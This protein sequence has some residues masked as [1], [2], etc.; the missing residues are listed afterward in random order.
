MNSQ[1]CDILLWQYFKSCLLCISSSFNLVLH[2]RWPGR[3]WYNTL[4]IAILLLHLKYRSCQTFT[5]CY[6]FDSWLLSA[7]Y[8]KCTE[9]NLYALAQQA[10]GS[11]C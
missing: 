11:E 9:P 2:T 3:K 1:A 7:H 5:V 10:H 8:M 6:R 4:R